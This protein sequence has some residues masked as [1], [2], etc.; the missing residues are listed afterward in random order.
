MAACTSVGGWHVRVPG[1]DPH[2]EG[3]IMGRGA[4]GNMVRM[5]N[6]RLEHLLGSALGFRNLTIRPATGN[7]S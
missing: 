3:R 4:A 1:P 6:S 2:A 7:V 5:A